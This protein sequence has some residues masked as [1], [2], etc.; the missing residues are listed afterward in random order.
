MYVYLRANRNVVRV[1]NVTLQK[2]YRP[3]VGSYS[4]ERVDPALWYKVFILDSIFIDCDRRSIYWSCEKNGLSEEFHSVPT[5]ELRYRNVVEFFQDKEQ[6]LKDGQYYDFDPNVDELF[7]TSRIIIRELQPDKID[8]EGNVTSYGELLKLLHVFILPEVYFLPKDKSKVQDVL[9][10]IEKEHESI[11][12]SIQYKDRAKKNTEN[13]LWKQRQNILRTEKFSSQQ[14]IASLDEKFLRIFLQHVI[15]DLRKLNE[16]LL[17]FEGEIRP[18]RDSITEKDVTKLNNARSERD[19]ILKSIEVSTVA[20]EEINNVLFR[21]H[22]KKTFSRTKQDPSEFHQLYVEIS[23]RL[24]QF[25]VEIRDVINAKIKV[26]CVREAVILT[27]KEIEADG[28]SYG[29]NRKKGT[30]ENETDLF[31]PSRKP[32]EWSTL[33][34]KVKTYLIV[35]QAGYRRKYEK[36]CQMIKQKCQ[37]L[38]DESKLF[39][40]SGDELDMPLSPS[41]LQFIDTIGNETQSRRSNIY[42]KTVSVNPSEVQTRQ[43]TFSTRWSMGSISKSS[44]ERICKDVTEHISCMSYDLSVEIMEGDASKVQPGFV[45]KV[46]TC[47]EQYVSEEIMPV[48]CELYER[49]YKNQCLNLSEWIKRYSTTEVGYGENTMARFLDTSRS[50]SQD[51]SRIP[52]ETDSDDFEEIEAPPVPCGMSKTNTLGGLSLLDLPIETLYE[53]FNDQCESMPQSFVGALDMTGLDDYIDVLEDCSVREITLSEHAQPS[54]VNGHAITHDNGDKQLGTAGLLEN[55]G[56]KEDLD[57]G[58]VQMRKHEKTEDSLHA[59]ARPLKEQFFSMFAKFFE[60]IDEENAANT[61]FSKLRHLTRAVKF[62][63]TQISKYQPRGKE[64]PLCADDLLDVLILLL[65]KLDADKFLCLYA[66]LNLLIQVSP[67]F[68]QGNAHD[69]SLVTMQVAYQHL[70]EQQL[71]HKTSPVLAS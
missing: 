71:L 29:Y 43:R 50:L 25:N 5:H 3:S 48:L 18:L 1:L 53:K 60:I 52:S 6:I 23:K 14:Y 2:C 20:R 47:Y 16:L 51:S 41:T 33:N 22:I 49:S 4:E 10:H 13:S 19:E 58:S 37:R 38:F 26:S 68:M 17:E 65:C 9:E 40:A 7:E 34:D 67:P 54:Q 32:E 42:R 36:F 12:E 35:K 57:T 66:H 70:F 59:S 55:N 63:E 31:D 8:K 24:D 69:Y 11:E 61:L 28:K 27:L 56:L 62:I 44:C 21:K 45:N 30:F 39:S 46:Y 15:K 64:V